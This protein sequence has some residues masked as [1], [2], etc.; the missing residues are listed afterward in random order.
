MTDSRWKRLDIDDEDAVTR[1]HEQARVEREAQAEVERRAAADRAAEEE[2]TRRTESQRRAAEAANA[3]AEAIERRTRAVGERLA[4]RKT[5][6]QDA[7]K[8]KSAKDTANKVI[9]ALN[10][11]KYWDDLHEGVDAIMQAVEDAGFEIGKAGV[12]TS[13]SENGTRKIYGLELDADDNYGLS[14]STYQMHSGRW[15]ITAYVS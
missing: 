15:E 7:R 6:V 14:I 3:E 4:Q 2:S 9:A 5:R 13:V 12:S 10:H 11:N 1:K 8:R